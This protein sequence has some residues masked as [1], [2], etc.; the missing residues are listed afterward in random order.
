[1]VFIRIDLQN[2]ITTK[3]IVGKKLDFREFASLHIKHD[4]AQRGESFYVNP[5]PHF[6]AT[7]MMPATANK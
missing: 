2:P 6:G 4:K 3:Q 7:R 5:V 1:M